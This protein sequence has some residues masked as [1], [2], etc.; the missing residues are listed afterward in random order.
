MMNAF[1]QEG[2]EKFKKRFPYETM[3]HEYFSYGKKCYELD[4][5]FTRY[6]K[7]LL[8]DYKYYSCAVKIQGK[9]VHELI[10]GLKQNGFYCNIK[11]ENAWFVLK[12]M[13][14][15]KNRVAKELGYMKRLVR[16]YASKACWRASH[17]GSNANGGNLGCKE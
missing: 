4:D 2:F 12:G 16:I 1:D 14:D 5:R 9:I 3:V 15:E 11:R 7:C 6:R 10:S 8:S 13:R 17:R